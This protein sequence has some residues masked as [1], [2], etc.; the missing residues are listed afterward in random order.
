MPATSLSGG[1]D[2]GFVFF[3]L[4]CFSEAA[5]WQRQRGQRKAGAKNHGKAERDF[6]LIGVTVPISCPLKRCEAGG[7][8]EV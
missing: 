1:G 2:N 5:F 3:S 8:I 7:R 6:A 4:H